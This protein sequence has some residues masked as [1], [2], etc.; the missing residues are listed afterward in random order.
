MCDAI[1]HRG[2]DDVG[3][4]TDAI[5]SIGMRRLSIIDLTTGRQ[6]VRNEDG[7]IWVVFNGEIYNYRELRADLEA[8]GHRFHT[9]GDTEPIVHLYEEYGADA[10]RRLRG[11]FGLAIWDVP[12]R[13]LLLARDRLGIK[14]LFY[15]EL[16]GGLAFASELKALM[17]LPQVDRRLS[18]SALGHVFTSLG[19]PPTQSILEGVRKLDAGYYAMADGRSLRS[20]RYWD[21]TFAPLSGA[22]EDD[23]VDRLRAKLDETVAAHLMSDVPLGAFLSGGLDSSAVVRAMAEQAGGRVKTFSIGFPDARFDERAHARRVAELCGTD[24]HELVVEPQP[25]DVVEDIVWHL[26]EP[27]GDSSAI[28]T[29]LVSRLAAEHVKVVLT[30]DGG[31]ELFGGYDK[32][33]VEAHER[34]YDRVPAVLRRPLGLIGRVLPVGTPGRRFLNHFAL[35]GPRR[36][37]D[38]STLFTRLDQAH[39][40]T[41]EAFE[42]MARFD[43]WEGALDALSRQRGHWLSALQ[44]CDLR[45]YLPLDILV[46]VDRMTMAHAIEARPALLD[47]EL[48]EFAAAIPPSL[49]LRQ[50]TTKHLFKRALAGRL[51]AEIIDRPKRGFAAPLAGWFRGPWTGF[52]HELLLS[53]RSRQRGILSALHLERLL[54]LNARGRELDREL[55]TLVSFELWC[56]AFLDRPPQPVP[57]SARP[58]APL[59]SL[60]EQHAC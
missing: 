52:A 9:S 15:A 32:Y 58:R 27:F 45:S 56:R 20:T 57:Q 13:R 38:A 10:I 25:L 43:P 59:T 40:L 29:Y 23:L 35:D 36:Y 3:V 37:L 16:P 17:Q 51:P 39:L 22:T 26:D 28:P 5:A 8:R 30:G 33:V 6:P 55:W 14:P 18:W 21:V 1:V 53:G 60:S 12:R 11:M 19:T 4:Y 48:V 34:R 24:H 31:D 41:P 2:P 42:Q 44:Y 46:K 7:S 54:R 49:H 47:H 50:G